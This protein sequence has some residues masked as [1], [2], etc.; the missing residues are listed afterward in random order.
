MFL[1]G[2]PRPGHRA[3]HA[4]SGATDPRGFVGKGIDK[5]I[6][7]RT[8][9]LFGFRPFLKQLSSGRVTSWSGWSLIVNRKRHFSILQKQQKQQGTIESHTGEWD[10]RTI[11]ILRAAVNSFAMTAA[12]CD[13]KGQR[14]VINDRTRVEGAK[15]GKANKCRYT[16]MAAVRYDS[17][18]RSSTAKISSQ[19]SNDIPECTLW[20]WE[21]YQEIIFPTRV[22]NWECT[23]MVFPKNVP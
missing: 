7:R 1:G 2:K 5:Y 12:G 23:D 15:S 6:G 17:A 18:L 21:M 22:L 11:Q 13:L 9:W 20:L 10:R 16:S 4:W 8:D 3:W 14:S 19:T